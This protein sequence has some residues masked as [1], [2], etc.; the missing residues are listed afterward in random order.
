MTKSIDTMITKETVKIIHEAAKHSF[1]R[2]SKVLIMGIFKY[3]GV[4]LGNLDFH[5]Y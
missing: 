2:D 5:G 4:D 3:K 1:V